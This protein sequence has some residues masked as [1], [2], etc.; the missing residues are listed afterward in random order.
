[1][2]TDSEEVK[3][4]MEKIT[5]AELKEITKQSIKEATSE[6]LDGLMAKF[7]R[8]SIITLAGFFLLAVIYFILW[9]QG[10]QPPVPFHPPTK[11]AP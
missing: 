6:W 5:E 4:V 7:G 11:V 10:L 9:T 1:M 8:F 2:T 3:R